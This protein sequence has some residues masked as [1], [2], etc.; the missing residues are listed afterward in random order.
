MSIVIRYAVD[1]VMAVLILGCLTYTAGG[2]P[3]ARRKAASIIG[4]RTSPR[5]DYSLIAAMEQ[6]VYGEAF[7]HDGA[8]EQAGILVADPGSIVI[9]GNTFDQVGS[10]YG[11]TMA[12]FADGMSRLVASLPPFTHYQPANL[13]WG[14]RKDPQ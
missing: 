9:A 11:I 4:P 8:P 6:E 2:G 10:A 3:A 5:P 14:D 13:P 1:V 12:E 7:K